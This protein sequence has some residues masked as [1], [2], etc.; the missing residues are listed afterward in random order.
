[1][2]GKW[3]GVYLSIDIVKDTSSL[4]TIIQILQR[5]DQTRNE[6]CMT[7][8]LRSTREMIQITSIPN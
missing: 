5:T 8:Q 3:G 1:M 7:L 6:P 2:S 4:Q